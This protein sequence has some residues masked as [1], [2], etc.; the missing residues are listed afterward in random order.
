MNWLDIALI[1][2][3]G[4][5]AYMGLKI[6]LIRA[7]FTAI[8]V[9]V[10]TILGGQLSDDVG[11]LIAGVNSDG[12]VASVISYAIIITVCLGAAAAASMI[13]R[14]VISVLL[15]GW[16]DKLA[17]AALRIMIGAGISA[18]IIMGMANLTYSEEVGDELAEKVLNSTLDTDKAKKR[19]E[20]GLTG[21]TL[22]TTFVDMIDIVPSST[23]W[24][25]PTNFKSALDVLDY[26]Q[27]L[28][29]R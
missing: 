18:G 27:S 17:G 6:G 28:G 9:F 2:V 5:S 8:G 21:S 20:G 15:M 10:G 12:T 25:V 14:K 4:V 29:A 16:A 13:L 7:G 3:V 23:L 1:L 26:K 24:F 11:A 22:T 19:L